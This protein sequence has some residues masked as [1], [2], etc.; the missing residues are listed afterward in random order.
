MYLMTNESW[1]FFPENLIGESSPP[2][3]NTWV[4]IA[5]TK[6]MTRTQREAARHNLNYTNRVQFFAIYAKVQGASRPSS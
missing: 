5:S 6:N 4:S 1:K 3:E 2:F